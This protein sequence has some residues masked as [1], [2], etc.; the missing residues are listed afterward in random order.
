MITAITGALNRVLD[1]EVR[2]RTGPFEYAVLVP[3]FVRRQLQTRLGEE[4]TLHTIQF[5]EGNQ[6]SNRWVPRLV[7]FLNEDELAFFE[8]L[9]TVDKVGVKKALKALAR[10]PREV[11]DAI[12]REDAKWL[13]TLPGFGKAMAES[14]MTA[15]KRKVTRFALSPAGVNGTPAPSAAAGTVIEDAYR[16][17]LSVGHNPADARTRLDSVLAGG[18]TFESVEALLTAIYS[19]KG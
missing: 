2:L 15:L 16:A 8:L 4:L 12:Q 19:H 9:C 11:A 17:L 18:K 10:P 7:G 14:V 13:S 6:M 1:E 5:L 3:E